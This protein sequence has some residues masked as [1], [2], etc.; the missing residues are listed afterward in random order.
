MANTRSIE[1]KWIEN[2]KKCSLLD[3]E[4]GVFNTHYANQFFYGRQDDS[5]PSDY[6]H[7]FIG[8]YS[9]CENI[10]R[11]TAIDNLIEFLHFVGIKIKRNNIINHLEKYP[12]DFAKMTKKCRYIFKAIAHYDNTLNINNPYK[13][14]SGDIF[15]LSRIESEESIN[16][17]QLNLFEDIELPVLYKKLSNLPDKYEDDK[18]AMELFR[19][20]ENS[21]ESFF[22]TGKA[23]TGKSTFIHYF[24][25]NTRKNV[26]MTAF[27]GIA[28]INVGGQTINSFFRFP[29]KPLLP[30]DHEIKTFEKYSQKFKIIEKINTIVIDEVS[31]LRS[32]ILEAIDFSLRKNG[33]NP[34]KLF[35]GK[36]LIFVGDIFQLPP[37]MAEDIE[38]IQFDEIYKSEYFFDAHSYK[39]LIPQ[40][41]EFKLSHR[42]KDD[43]EFVRLLDKVRVCQVDDATLN[44][45]N[46]RYNPT[47]TPKIEEFVINLTA[48]NALANA[49]NALKLREL[50]YSELPPFEAVIT[51]EFQEQ[52]Y[53]TSKVL[54]LKKNA[55]II[56]VK[57]DT[58]K[59]W[60]NGTIAKIDFIT[61]DLIEVRL[62]NGNIH[63]LEKEI[64]ENRKYKYDKE[65]KKIVSEVIGTFSQYPIK[66]AWAITIHKSQ[67]LTFDNV[68][69]D[70]GSG[71]FVNG[72]VYTALSRCRT[73]NGI[74]LKSKLNHKDIISDKR[75]I[76]FH[77]T[78]QLL[79]SIED[80]ED[81]I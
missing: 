80:M 79:H 53:P 33:G 77:E 10:D 27:T 5:Y 7:N 58:G 43:L 41:F 4:T 32:D 45:L 68:I 9:T 57:N 72:Q 55:Q 54:E 3:D 59:R 16:G 67:G 62:Q 65:K 56:F 18:I 69:I 24:A 73:F 52:K 20:I 50:P 26:L 63:K 8:F 1:R 39:K 37:I 14:N 60:V 70:L 51:G 46:E 17:G 38:G 23:G 78:E 61:K 35:G 25:Q 30:E 13:D 12:D 6:P 64:W 75:I 49:E 31:M 76:D 48:N 34:N 40:Y 71:A 42:Q 11:D 21:N 36:Q 66:L 2:F 29:L 19:R 74:T 15:F 47:Y 44:K 22:I 81:D 28:A